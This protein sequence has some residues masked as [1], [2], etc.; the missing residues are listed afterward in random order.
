MKKNTFKSLVTEW[1]KWQERSV[2]E[3]EGWEQVVTW[4]DERLVG[5]R[6]GTAVV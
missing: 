4:L 3:E 6:A 5:G 1:G 2:E